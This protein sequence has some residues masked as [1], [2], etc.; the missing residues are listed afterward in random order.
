MER[1][2]GKVVC[3]DCPRSYLRGVLQRDLDCPPHLLTE[4]GTPRVLRGPPCLHPPAP[5]PPHWRQCQRY[6]EFFWLYFV[7]TMC[8]M[9]VCVCVFSIPLP[10]IDIQGYSHSSLHSCQAAVP[11]SLRRLFRFLLLLQQESLPHGENV[12]QRLLLS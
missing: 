1:S 12:G 11:A 6:V 4:V 2:L 3:L 7:P 5:P 8:D 9:S 10:C